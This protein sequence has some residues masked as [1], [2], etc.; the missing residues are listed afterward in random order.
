MK[1][2]VFIIFFAGVVSCKPPM[3][4]QEKSNTESNSIASTIN[5]KGFTPGIIK[6]VSY[7]SDCEFV[8]IISESVQYDPINLSEAFKID[9]QEVWFK[10]VGLRRAN[11]CL[12]VSP[13]QITK[14]TKKQK[15]DN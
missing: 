15:L 10:F 8:I 12:D 6:K 11:R 3:A 7:D 9:G 14:M 2:L 4:L 1:Y 13:I 5:D